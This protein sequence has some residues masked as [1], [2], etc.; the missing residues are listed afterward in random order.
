VFP[1]KGSELPA[2][3][4]V[5]VNR[6]D[7]VVEIEGSDK[8]W[9]TEQLDRLSV[10]YTDPPGEPTP[11]TVA[12]IPA[13]DT[14]PDPISVPT[15]QKPTTPKRPRTGRSNRANRNSELEAKLTPDIRAKLQA[16]RDER[17]AKWKQQ[18]DQ[19]VIIAT[20][21]M[22]ELGTDGSIDDDDLY[23]VYSAMG[24]PGPSNYRA[25]ITNAR[26]R[27][28]YFGVVVDGRSQITHAG[29][30]FGRHGSKSS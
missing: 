29:E 23:T 9:I 24:W 16:Y 28:G 6:R 2:D 5:R 3:Y 22:D 1:K 27:K 8:D 15:T 11:A 20:F 30:Q 14:R 7:G 12:A 26:Q 25:V 21:L 13:E 18:P 4:V 10:V 17:E 19:A